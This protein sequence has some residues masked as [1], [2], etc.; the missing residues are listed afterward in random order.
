MSDVGAM[1]SSVAQLLE[2][3]HLVVLSED[4]A[5]LDRFV[6][7]A[8][9]SLESLSGSRVIIVPGELTMSVDAVCRLMELHCGSRKR[10]PRTVEGLIRLLRDHTPGGRFQY[11]IWRNADAMLEHDVHLFSEVVNAL[12]GVAAERE[13][14]DPDMLELQ[15]FIF[16]GGEKLGA[17]AEEDGGQFRTWLA[18]NGSA[19]LAALKD[20]VPRPPVLTLRLDG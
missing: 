7:S 13:H 8:W 19:S 1:T 10:I 12:M 2:E 14:I 15:R 18:T 20:Y 3:H 11:V 17:Y 9:R 6:D 5:R 16:I 4:A